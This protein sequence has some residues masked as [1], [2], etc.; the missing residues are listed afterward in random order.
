MDIVIS[1]IVFIAVAFV[2]I[3]EF[4]QQKVGVSP[5]PTVGRVRNKIL[6]Q[7]PS[8]AHHVV[9]LGS[10]WGGI[11]LLAGRRY[12]HMQV[13]GIEL[14]PVPYLFSRL[15]LWISRAPNVRFLRR[16]FFDYP[17]D[18]SDVVI[19]Y[20]TNPLMAQLKEKLLRE[21]PVHA[22]I[23]SSTFFIPGWTPAKTE[24]VTGLWDT[25]VYVYRRKDA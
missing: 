25:D 3:N 4:F 13:T 1:A 7:V 2:M 22:V 11:S 19:C 14:S 23:V 16:N 12:P 10:G 15:R 5:M 18:Q 21:L 6:A 20:L 9:E 17:L 24:K 8:S